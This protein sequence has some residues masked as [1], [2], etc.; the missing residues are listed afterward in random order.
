MSCFHDLLKRKEREKGSLIEMLQRRHKLSMC[1]YFQ[2]F[3]FNSKNQFNRFQAVFFLLYFSYAWI[4]NLYYF[5]NI[6]FIIRTV[7]A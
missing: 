5:C 6:I 1:E 4:E 7:P 3:L 2:L